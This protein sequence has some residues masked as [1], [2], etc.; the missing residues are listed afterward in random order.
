MIQKI[1]IFNF[2]LKQ[3]LDFHSYVE[4]Y[5]ESDGHGLNSE[6]P[7]LNPKDALMV[8]KDAIFN[9]GLEQKLEHHY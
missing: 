4:F 1:E 5:G 7:Q 6:N 2:D 8:P 9:F 3:K